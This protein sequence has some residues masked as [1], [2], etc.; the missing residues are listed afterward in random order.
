MALRVLYI[1]STGH[2][3]GSSRSL[4]DLVRSFPAGTVEAK[5][6][7]QRGRVAQV[8]REHGVP[9]LETAGISIFDNTGYSHYRGL[10]WIVLLRELSYL[11]ATV[12][13]LRRAKR[14][15]GAFDIVHVNDFTLLLPAILAKLMFNV[16]VVVHCRA[17]QRAQ[18]LRT[19][20]ITRLFRKYADKVLAIDKTVQKTLPASL[21]VICIHNGFLPKRNE[22]ALPTRRASFRVALVGGLIPAKGIFEFIEAAKI[23][24]AEGMDAEF[25]IAGANFRDLSGV[26]GRIL[27]W[28]GFA[29]DLESEIAQLIVRHRLQAKVKLLGFVE[30]ITSFYD[31]ID[32]LCFPTH[33]NAI[34]RPVYEAGFSRVPSIA[35]VTD[36]E[37]DTLIDGV[38]GLAIPPRNPKALA[39]A[40]SCVYKDRALLRRLGDGAFKLAEQNFDARKN[41][42]EMLLL[43]GSLTAKK[44]ENV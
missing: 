25:L 42:L 3:G 13:G 44:R 15:W 14:E 11:P 19:R 34:G 41:A 9:T 39:E 4:L 32:V 30:D 28:S 35:T 29:H 24:V 23:C 36:P 40:I 27:K 22:S 31:S 33:V 1:H 37:D 26:K 5:L 2:F 18:G 43:Y 16:P 21:P 7:T 20:W 8:F 38:T 10:R 6:L 17:L 12:S